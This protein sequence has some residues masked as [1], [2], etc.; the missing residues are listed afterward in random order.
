[1][2]SNNNTLPIPKFHREDYECW[3]IKMKNLLI[4]KGLW[5]IVEGGY[6]DATYWSTLGDQAKVAKKLTETK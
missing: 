2:A 4:G 3:S 5:D 1:M 6:S